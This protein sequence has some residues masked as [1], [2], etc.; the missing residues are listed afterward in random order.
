[1]NKVKN[2]WPLDRITKVNQDPIK[3]VDQLSIWGSTDMRLVIE[4][5]P[6]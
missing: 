1:M 4:G 2:V 5:T 6:R 3:G